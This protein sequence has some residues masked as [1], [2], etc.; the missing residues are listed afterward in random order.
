V[1]VEEVASVEGL[2]VVVG[3]D[4]HVEEEEDF[5]L[6][7]TAVNHPVEAIQ[8]EV[9]AADT[10]AAEVAM[11]VEE[12]VMEVVAATTRLPVFCSL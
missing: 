1:D 3:V 2:V 8:G 10:V 9:E 7:P 11:G 4:F 12:A 6:D 5:D